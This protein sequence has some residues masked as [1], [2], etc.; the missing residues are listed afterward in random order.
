MSQKV[1]K[2]FLTRGVPGTHDSRALLSCLKNFKKE[3]FNKIRIPQFNKS[4]DDRYK[5]KDW[6]KIFKKPDI[7][8]FEG[9]CVG[10]K[11]QLKNSLIKPINELERYQDKNSIWR[12]KVNNELKNNYKKIF[13]LI[14]FL[15]FLKVPSFRYVYKWRALQE[16]K[17]K[18]ASKGKRVMSNLQI[19]KFIMFYERTTRQML[20]TLGPLSNIVINIDTKHC[21]KSMKFN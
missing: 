8:I 21:L 1:S 10:A 15:I 16:K 4:N 7:V 2:L 20:K 5:K 6:I 12:C 19:K 13:K 14:D 18:K 11:P 3:Y 17:L 9:W